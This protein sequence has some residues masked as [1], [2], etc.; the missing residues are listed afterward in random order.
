[1]Q[2][3]LQSHSGYKHAITAPSAKL[4]HH[5]VIGSEKTIKEAK[6]EKRTRNT[7]KRG[8]VDGGEGEGWSQKD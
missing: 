6:A 1:M 7:R 8:L 2:A 4:T 3:E 5:T